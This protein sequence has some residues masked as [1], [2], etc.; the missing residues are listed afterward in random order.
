[1]RQELESNF[2]YTPD[3]TVLDGDIMQGA[4]VGL[5]IGS[6][7]PVDSNYDESD[8]AEDM[9]EGA[10]FK[11]G[12]GKKILRGVLTGGV[13]AIAEGIKKS[14]A[15]KQASNIGVSSNNPVSKA[16]VQQT[17]AVASA[18]A[19]ASPGAALAGAL[20]KPILTFNATTVDPPTARLMSG[21][22]LRRQ[23]EEYLLALTWSSVRVTKVSE[24]GTVTFTLSEAA[25]AGD[26]KWTLNEVRLVPTFIVT[27]ASSQ[28]NAVS[29][30]TISFSLGAAATTSPYGAANISTSQWSVAR[31]SA[32]KEVKVLFFP[33]VP[34]LDTI[35]PSLSA[36]KAGEVATIMTVTGV[37][38]GEQVTL[39]IPGA[40][41]ND[42][43]SFL[44]TFNLSL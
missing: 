6:V 38:V 28:L 11:N 42:M 14:V 16:A 12:R 39:E 36:L 37:A 26:F 22:L 21:N 17:A 9:G 13:S 41:S 31:S 35:V 43:I 40:N 27:L 20:L 19:N 44:R 25:R 10:I 18:V 7:F 23:L 24:N 3:F 32:T 34:V 8:D 1:M 2:G 15:A 5:S 4:P 30:G 33:Y 29:G